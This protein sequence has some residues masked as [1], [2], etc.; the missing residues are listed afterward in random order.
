MAVTMKQDQVDRAHTHTH[1][2]S[3]ENLPAGQNQTLGIVYFLYIVFAAACSTT[4]TRVY[5]AATIIKHCRRYTYTYS[6]NIRA[7]IY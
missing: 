4:H 5:A 2:W 1:S 3:D 6:T 7:H